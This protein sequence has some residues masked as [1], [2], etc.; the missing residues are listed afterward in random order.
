M[1]VIVF[2]Y[3][4]LLKDVSSGGTRHFS[5]GNERDQWW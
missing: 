2:V 1:K 5:G 4:C 3:I